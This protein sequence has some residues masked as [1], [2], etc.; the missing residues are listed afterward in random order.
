M[1]KPTMHSDNSKPNTFLEAVQSTM[2]NRLANAYGGSEPIVYE[3]TDDRALLHQYFVL[4]EAMYRK[5][6]NTELFSGEEDIYDKVSHILIARRGKLCLGGCRL[7]IRDPEENWDLPMEGKDFHLREKFPEYPLKLFRHGE[8]SRFAVM[9]D[10]GSDD[11]I[12]YSLCSIM[13]EKVINEKVHFLFAKSTLPLARNWRLVANGFG[14]KTTKIR[15]DVDVPENPIHPDVKWYIT[16][17][18]I[19]HLLDVSNERQPVDVKGF[20]EPRK[21]FIPVQ[22]ESSGLYLVERA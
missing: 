3:F 13:Y 9:E 18:Q 1:T 2:V 19:S 5:M 11:N 7:T 6:F 15:M 17:S 20:Y 22:Q 21:A 4:R 14:V 8:I 10:S 12:F 16:E